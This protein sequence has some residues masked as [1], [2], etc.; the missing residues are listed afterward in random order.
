MQGKALENYACMHICHL[1]SDHDHGDLKDYNHGNP[2]AAG[3]V[4]RSVA[5]NAGY[6]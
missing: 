5:V 6:D 3:E 4:K 1:S 2:M